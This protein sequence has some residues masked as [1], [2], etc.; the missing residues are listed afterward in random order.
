MLGHFDAAQMLAPM[1]IASTLGIGHVR[2]AMIA[3]FALGLGGNAITLSSALFAGMTAAGA[4]LA[5]GPTAM[6][7]ALASVV[8][9]R[10]ARGESPLT[11]AVVHPFSA[12][13]Y[14]LRYWLAAAGVD[15]DRDVGIVVLPPSLMVDAV[16]ERRIDGF[17]AGEP[18][19]SLA[20]EAGAGAIAVMKSALWRQGPE[21]VLGLRADFAERRPD[22]LLAL[23]RALY[24]A[25]EWAGRPDNHAELARVLAAP[26]YVGAPADIVE[27][28]L[29]GRLRRIAGGAPETIPDFMAFH[30]HA[31]NFP[32]KSHALWFYS[33]MARWGQLTH[34]A[35]LAE[36]AA[37]VYRPDLYRA[38]LA[39]LGVDLPRASAKVEGALAMPTPVASRNGAM[40]LGPDGFFDGRLFDPDRI[41]DYL[42]SFAGDGGT[43]RGML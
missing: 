26:P 37:S 1:P 10:Q 5:A 31:A 13:N 14:E 24:R 39:G 41:E 29:S 19:N 36:E 17:C 40:I 35:T 23:L 6:G 42:A 34:S 8:A 22:T 15:P 27:R 38:A 9:R 18:W 33:Q 25:A 16:V 3:P 20:V 21:K 28:A 11:L 2:C 43:A 32:W 12:H 30:D 7:A 4:D